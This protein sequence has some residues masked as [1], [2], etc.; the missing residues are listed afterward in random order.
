M[1]WSWSAGQLAGIDLRIHA[2]FLLLLGWVAVSHWVASRSLEGMMIGVGIIGRSFGAA[3]RN[4]PHIPGSP[5]R[6]N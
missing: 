5:I 1:K 2:T 4:D 3:D 6:N